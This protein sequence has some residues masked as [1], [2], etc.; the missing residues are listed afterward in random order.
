MKI[1][2]IISNKD[3]ASLNIYNHMD[4]L[5]EDKYLSAKIKKIDIESVYYDCNSNPDLIIFASKH[6][7]KQGQ[8]AFSA[9]T[10][11]NWGNNQLGG[12]KNSFSTSPAFLLRE[13]LL[14]LEK[15]NLGREVFLE[16][17]HHGPTLNIPSIFIEIG[18]KYEEWIKD[19]NGKVIANVI[20]E[21][22]ETLEPF[23]SYEEFEKYYRKQ[24]PLIQVAVGVGGLHHTPNFKK[25][26]LSGQIA[27]GHCCAKYNL[28]DFTDETLEKAIKFT[29]EKV[30]LI[31]VDW[32]GVGKH[33]Q[34]ISEIL[35]KKEK[36]W[37]KINTLKIV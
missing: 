32:K 36:N 6:V 14:K 28:D 24:N 15:N 8:P 21:L 16:V 3:E 19:E 5:I 18:S 17:S 27:L 34:N 22:I 7:S 31:L 30:D 4:Y 12:E 33:K 26:I 23:S 29:A 1:E 25:H 13:T 11:G 35:L 10:S 9:H 20:K 2:I 37:K